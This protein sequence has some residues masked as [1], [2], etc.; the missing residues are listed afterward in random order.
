MTACSHTYL[1]DVFRPET[2]LRTYTGFAGPLTDN[3]ITRRSGY[4]LSHTVADLHRHPTLERCCDH[5]GTA[6]RCILRPA[7]RSDR[8][9]AAFASDFVRPLVQPPTRPSSAASNASGGSHVTHGSL[10]SD[11]GFAAL[12]GKLRIPADAREHLRVALEDWRDTY[13]FGDVD[14]VFMS[15]RA[16]FP[17][18]QL[19]KIVEGCARFLTVPVVTPRVIRQVAKWDSATDAH[20]DDLAQVISRWRVTAAPLATPKSQRQHKKPRADSETEPI[21]QPVFGRAGTAVDH[22]P[23][24]DVFG[25]PTRA[26]PATT[27][28]STSQPLRPP[29]SPTST[30]RATAH[31]FRDLPTSRTP[32][33]SSSHRISVPT[34]PSQYPRAPAPPFPHA[35]PTPWPQYYSPMPLYSSPLAYAYGS[36]AYY[37]PYPQMPPSVTPHFRAPVPSMQNTAS[38]AHPSPNTYTLPSTA[39]P[40]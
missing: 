6:H 24:A 29:F 22:A 20:L 28:A 2:G 3:D 32:Q 35:I 19:A 18:K 13:N 38:Q 31:S 8:R 26:R 14:T 39:P 36:P 16:Y 7:D 10:D 1:A 11:A 5:H 30:P 40:Q 15:R 17:P 23:L 27:H 9:L 37:V 4:D 34:T 33:A 12:N 21:I 25:T